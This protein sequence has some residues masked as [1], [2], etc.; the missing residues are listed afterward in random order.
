MW[1]SSWKFQI[2]HL[3]GHSCHIAYIKIIC[4]IQ[5]II[6]RTA[7]FMLIFHCSHAR[8]QTYIQKRDFL[9]CTVWTIVKV[10]H[11]IYIYY[12]R[13]ICTF[14]RQCMP[15]PFS[16]FFQWW[17]F[18]HV[19]LKAWIKIETQ[20]KSQFHRISGY[21]IINKNNSCFLGQREL[22][23][24]KQS[25]W[26]RCHRQ[27]EGSMRWSNPFCGSV[28][29]GRTQPGCCWW[30]HPRFVILIWINV[31]KNGLRFQQPDDT[32]PRGLLLRRS[33]I[34]WGKVCIQ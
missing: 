3:H 9:P 32:P 18:E 17:K 24:N 19:A 5:K 13:R 8:V 16:R 2:F 22:N 26:E 12:T 28:A 30:F 14:C 33:R 31:F 7:R 1:G 11:I 25:G 34:P 20:L 15:I 10:C 29:V 21:P 23:P 6:N 27:D 4:I